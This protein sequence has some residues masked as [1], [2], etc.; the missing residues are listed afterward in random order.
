MTKYQSIDDHRSVHP[1]LKA[2]NFSLV[3][4]RWANGLM[5]QAQRAPLDAKDLWPLSY[6]NQ[7][8]HI[9]DKFEAKFKQTKS[10]VTTFLSI[11][12]WRFLFIGQLQLIT[13]ACTLYGP[14]VLYLVLGEMEG[15]KKQENVS[16][17]WQ[18]IISLFFVKVFQAF[19]SSHT[20]FQNDTIVLRFTSAVQQLIFQKAL[21][22]DAKA[23]KEKTPSAVVNLF[24]SDINW[25]ISCSYYTHQIWIIPIQITVILYFLYNL[26]GS[27]A[28]I[29]AGII[30]FTLFL[31]NMLITAQRSVWKHF[32]HFKERRMEA[33]TDMFSPKPPSP[34]R[35]PKVPT[36]EPS[37]K[38][39]TNSSSKKEDDGETEI[40]HS[41]SSPKVVDPFEVARNDA[42]AARSSEMRELSKSFTVS[43]G[44]TAL[45]YS[46]PI[47]VTTASL[48][49]YTLVLEQSITAAKVFTALA[50]FRSLR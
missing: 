47:L 30:V 45:L 10:I 7:C 22:L 9:S 15:D 38:S 21:T 5:S 26:L 33:L 25:I 16:M 1:I 28:F 17:L 46:A 3:F 32:M 37:P 39:T 4:F 42:M 24:T 2:S 29:G 18:L 36:P 41:A 11:F 40:S 34:V 8:K 19:L 27:A 14:Y 20:A 12:G 23:Q 43:A 31:N 35:T 49:F 50:L 6:D 13:V 48:A 44:V